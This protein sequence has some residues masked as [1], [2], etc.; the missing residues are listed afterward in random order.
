MAEAQWEASVEMESGRATAGRL[1]KRYRSEE[2]L[3]HIPGPH[4]QEW[5]ARRT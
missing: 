2:G 3:A 1:K 5:V 4:R